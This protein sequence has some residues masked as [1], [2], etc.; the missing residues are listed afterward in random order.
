MG[1]TRLLIDAT[2]GICSELLLKTA[3]WNDEPDASL[4]RHCSHLKAVVSLANA[5]ETK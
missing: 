2:D 4:T 5:K 1:S 3:C